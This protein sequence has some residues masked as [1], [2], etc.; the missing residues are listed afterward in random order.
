MLHRLAA[1]LLLIP[2]IAACGGS[3]AS[4]APSTSAK[5]SGSATASASGGEESPSAAPTEAPS[6]TPSGPVTLIACEYGGPSFNASNLTGEPGAEQVDDPAATAFREFLAGPDGTDLPS[7]DWR[8]FSRAKELVMYGQDDPSGEEG[9]YLV[10]RAAFES[11]AWTV[12]GSAQC[13]PRIWWSDTYHLAADWKLSKKVPATATSFRALVTE[14]AC[15]SGKNA[16]GRMAKPRI[17]Y[18]ET[19]VTITIGVKPLEGD[20]D[21]PANPA[22]PLTIK[23]TEP[24]GDRTLFN[25]GPYPSVEVEQPS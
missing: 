23:L 25:G 24:L 6:P 7:G 11:G 9:L 13:R 14:V 18:D 10:A 8:E 12:S 22:T 19:S 2:L 3:S 5:A 4:T 20:Q 21:C 16:S 17:V 1:V 15:A